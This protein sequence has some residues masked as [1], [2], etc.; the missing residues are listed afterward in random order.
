MPN[1]VASLG[2]KEERSTIMVG[3]NDRFWVTVEGRNVETDVVKDV[4]KS[5]DFNKLA[6]M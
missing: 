4:I 2:I 6:G 5:V 1:W 3:V